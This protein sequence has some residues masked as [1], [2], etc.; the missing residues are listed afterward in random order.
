MS[1]QPTG[2]TSMLF[3]SEHVYGAAAGFL[4]QQF[5]LT[6]QRPQWLHYGHQVVT[7]RYP[8]W[9]VEKVYI[10]VASVQQTLESNPLYDGEHPLESPLVEQAAACLIQWIQ[11]CGEYYDKTY[12]PQL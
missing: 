6:K 11:D 9:S 12:P 1:H 7:E 10:V 5:Y 3:H 2:S 4:V 8:H